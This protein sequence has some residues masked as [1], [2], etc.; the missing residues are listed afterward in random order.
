MIAAI[1]RPVEIVV[2]DL[3]DDKEVKGLTKF[4]T[5]PKE[6]GGLGQTIDVLV[7]CGGIQRR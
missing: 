3:S 6:E 2:C 1:P 4:V 5:G 7:N